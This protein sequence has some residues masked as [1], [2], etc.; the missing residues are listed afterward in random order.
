MFKDQ[1]IRTL[2]MKGHRHLTIVIKLGM[3]K[4]TIG[5]EIAIGS[6]KIQEQVPS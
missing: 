3:F 6:Y 2:G 4:S 5:N 1:S